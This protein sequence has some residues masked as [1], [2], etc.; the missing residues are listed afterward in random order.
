[1]NIDAYL[2]TI[3]N[4]SRQFRFTAR[5]DLI[6]ESTVWELKCTSEITIE[7]L[8]QVIAYAWLWNM[9]SNKNEETP[10]K[11]FK[12][13]NIKTGDIL[14]LDATMDDLN[15][16]M[17]ELLVGK[18]QEIIPKTDDEFISECHSLLN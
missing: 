4:D 10:I 8:V 14:R 6:T 17:T 18:Y 9:R 12:I 11:A 13:F 16:I 3:F 15:Y 1:M 5:V 7:H 2:K